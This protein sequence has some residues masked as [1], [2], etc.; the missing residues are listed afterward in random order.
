M[1]IL[2]RLSYN[3]HD[4]VAQASATTVMNGCMLG[5][6]VPFRCE[7]SSSL[8]LSPSAPEFE[9]G[10]LTVMMTTFTRHR[11]TSHPS[12]RP[13]SPDAYS[14]TYA[15]AWETQRLERYFSIPLSFT[16]SPIPALLNFH[17]I[18]PRGPIHPF[19]SLFN[20]RACNLPIAL[21]LF[22]WLMGAVKVGCQFALGTERLDIPTQCF[23]FSYDAGC[24]FLRCKGIRNTMREF[25]PPKWENHPDAE[26]VPSLFASFEC[27]IVGHNLRRP[28]PGIPVLSPQS[29]SST[30]RP[31]SSSRVAWRGSIE[32]GD[33]THS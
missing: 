33:T 22:S 14:T 19:C 12:D 17:V 1:Q 10:A 25:L 13:S 3:S 24:D 16:V 15:Q 20:M 31:S 30:R 23:E 8:S 27:P 29:T 2:H 21:R 9:S 11:V 32:Q 4:T 28:G 18:T 5:M 7:S 6:I 26:R